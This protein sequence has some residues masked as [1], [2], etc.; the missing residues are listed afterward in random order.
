MFIY[1][2]SWLLEKS[3]ERAIEIERPKQTDR[4]REILVI[5]KPLEALL[6]PVDNTTPSAGSEHSILSYY[7]D[8]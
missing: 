4:E 2:G 7:I 3:A 8:T 6:V 1:V 5:E